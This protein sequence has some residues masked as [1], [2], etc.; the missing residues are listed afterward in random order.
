MSAQFFLLDTLNITFQTLLLR[1]VSILSIIIILKVYC[2][3]LPGKNIA[4]LPFIIINSI[5]VVSEHPKTRGSSTKHEAN[6]FIRVYF[7]E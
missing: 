6:N 7:L 3:H 1:R 5:Q 2:D 4:M